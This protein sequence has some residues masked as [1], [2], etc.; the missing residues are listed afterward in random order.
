MF[1]KYGFTAQSIPVMLHGIQSMQ[2][3]KPAK[4]LRTL[5]ANEGSLDAKAHLENYLPVEEKRDKKAW[6]YLWK[7]M[8]WVI[9]GQDSENGGSKVIKAAP[10]EWKE[11]YQENFR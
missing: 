10:E 8:I 7:G 2:E 11:W 1:K 5:I 3:L 4:E 9:W 6:E